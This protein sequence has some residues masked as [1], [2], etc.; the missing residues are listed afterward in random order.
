MTA[1]KRKANG[2]SSW[3]GDFTRA[4]GGARYREAA[5]IYAD[6]APGEVA[7]DVILLAARA[8]LVERP[9][10]AIKLLR[11]LKVLPTSRERA[12][13]DMILGEAFSRTQ[14]YASADSRLADALKL[15]E[16][17]D[18]RELVSEI[19]YRFVRRKLFE[20]STE[21]ARPYLE[22]IR[23]GRSQAARLNALHAE[24]FIL[25][26]EERVKEQAE[27][28]VELLRSVEPTSLEF[29]HHRAWATHTLSVL[30]RELYIPQALPEIERH[31]AGAWTDDYKSNRFQ[32]TKALGWTKALQGDYF[33]AFRHLRQAS[34]MAPG[35]AWKV[36]AAC[37]RAY[38][39]RCL[40]E[41]SWSRQE[42]DVA[43]Q[44]AEAVAWHVTLGEERIGLLLLAELFAPLDSAKSAM[45]LA[46]YRELGAIKSP[47]HRKQDARF[48][49]FAQ[50]STAVT[51]IALGNPKR[52]LKE[53]RAA[54]KIFER[55]GYDWR[56]ARCMLVEYG[57]TGNDD[58]LPAA[59]EKLRNYAQSW[60]AVELRSLGQQPGDVTLPPR[61][62][63][64]F[65]EVCQGKRTAEIAKALDR[66]EF[67]INN[68]L[69]EIF[70]AFKVKNRSALLAEA[71]RRGMIK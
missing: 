55:F 20:E 37:D 14:D 3:L 7:T 35:D 21:K 24:T 41:A 29:L 15:A 26:Y 40:R 66:S 63:R 65:E 16:K 11:G 28:L 31:L 60:L 8:H 9:A 38:L 61:Q 34:E 17:L 57:V 71:A 68:Q 5:A 49:A 69:K 43:E 64:V 56:L 36:V 52:A 59:A 4:Y 10:E 46:Q 47:L 19:G 1:A 42:L 53:L 54:A 6:N 45:Y 12:E 67:T 2:T 13:R 51:E 62:K 27:R 44:A 48:A 18:D 70:K 30:A 33:N 32:A 58:L 22:M 50:Y 23:R 39:A 25:G